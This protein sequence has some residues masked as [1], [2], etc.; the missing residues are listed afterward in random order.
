MT[1]G[2]GQPRTPTSD[3]SSSSS[4][5]RAPYPGD[6]SDD[7]M[8]ANGDESNTSITEPIPNF[9][10]M[11]VSTSPAST[12]LRARR[13]S[14]RGELRG[15]CGGKIAVE[16]SPMD[17]L[18]NELLILIF[19]K[20]THPTDLR[21]CM[22]VCTKWASCAVDQLWHRPYVAKW[23]QFRSVVETLHSENATFEYARL[24]KRLNLTFLAKQIS[25]GTVASLSMCGRLERLT[26]TNC[27][28]LTDS[29]LDNLIP[30]NPGLLALDLSN[31]FEL[32]D[33][34]INAISENCTRLQGL[35]IAGCNKVTD[36]SL[37]N[38]S[39]NCKLLKRL[40]LNECDN[41]T[42]EAVIAIAENCQQ[43]LEV[44]LQRCTEI[45]DT[46]VVH[47][48]KDLRQLRE[49]HLA[50]CVQITDEAF[51]KIPSHQIESLRNID[52]TNCELITDDAVIKIVSVAPRLRSLILAKCKNITDRGV[53]SITRL[54]KWIHYLALGHCS[55]IT[56]TSLRKIA[57]HCNRIRYIDL[58][59]CTH[60]TDDGVME[61]AQLPKLKRVGL[62]KCAKITNQSITALVAKPQACVLE[63][64][65]LSYCPKLTLS[66]IT[67][68]VNK[69][70]RLTHL[71]LT[72]I[73]TFY[74]NDE[75]S[76][77][78]REPP[79]E[80]TPHQREVF[81]VF[82]G[83]GVHKLRYYLNTKAKAPVDF[84]PHF[85]DHE[86]DED[87]SAIAE[88]EED[89]DHGWAGT[90]A[91]GYDGGGAGN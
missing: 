4:P 34:T 17:Q 62:V 20:L 29:G 23:E 74:S 85:F 14:S 35:N 2:R 57:R 81:C 71:S 90:V 13:T 11:A 19:S 88:Q 61:L 60:L 89:I 49:L 59:G 66:G 77:F 42:D 27:R 87:E 12:S 84:P 79:D 72:G 16:M 21:N 25:D 30:N 91:N 48:F 36:S 38:L 65:H 41:L 52:L 83:Q 53:E 39:K 9:R 80:F 37:V 68:L 70:Q 45:T 56:D 24:I 58:A 63:R 40:K 55:H 86:E 67:K 26:L 1:K 46:A 76:K 33:R 47:L 44:D 64:V 50:F 10:N 75:L 54:G 51:Y 6:D 78:C 28:D 5:E 18:P 8:L 32:T 3:G 69:C 22:L 31:L 82:S 43:L 15:F 73:E 7:F